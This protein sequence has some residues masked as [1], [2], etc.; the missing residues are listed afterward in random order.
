MDEAV[1]AII[2]TNSLLLLD[3]VSKFAFDKTKQ[4]TL[5]KAAIPRNDYLLK[6]MVS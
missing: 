5:L 2:D 1:K 6:Q 3:V 4:F